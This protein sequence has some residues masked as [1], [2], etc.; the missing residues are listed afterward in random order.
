MGS[1]VTAKCQCGLELQLSLG[2]GMH[3]FTSVCNFPCLCEACHNVVQVNLL[4]KTEECPMCKS[5]D[6]IPYDDPRLRK[7]P[8]TRTVAE[9][10]LQERV[11]RRLV[12]T[13]ANYLCPKC[14]EMSL[15]FT[16]SGCWD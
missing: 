16:E 12:L 13:D 7:S 3:S 2:G 6:L 4:A 11:G 14:K 5:L 9:W 1:I 15:R 10:N 8:G